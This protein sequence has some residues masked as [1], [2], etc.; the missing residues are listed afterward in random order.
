[1]ARRSTIP[2]AKGPIEALL[3]DAFKEA[4]RTA[5]LSLAQTAE[6]LGVGINTIR[7]H[8]AGANI[9]GPAE[10]LHASRI[11][12]AKPEVLGAGY[13]ARMELEALTVAAAAAGLKV[14]VGAWPGFSIDMEPIT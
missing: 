7:W 10:L 12:G 3:G 8:E 9:M 11:L 13:R 14:T 6:A 4:R 1:M 2:E 5:G